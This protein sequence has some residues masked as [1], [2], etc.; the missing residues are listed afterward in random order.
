[1]GAMGKQ[2]STALNKQ[3]EAIK[4]LKANTETLQET[5]QVVEERV[6]NID[7][8]D[9]SQGTILQDPHWDLHQGEIHHL[10]EPQNLLERKGVP[11]T[12]SQKELEPRNLKHL[13]EKEDKKRKS[14]S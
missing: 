14:S 8:K 1:M 9:Y 4:K 7:I 10:L 2:V 12:K 3:K 11:K 13:M 5:L 6:S